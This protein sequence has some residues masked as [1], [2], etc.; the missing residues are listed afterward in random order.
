MGNDFNN[1]LDTMF[2]NAKYSHK[3]CTSCPYSLL[4]AK[5]KRIKSKMI[6]IKKTALNADT[7]DEY[8]QIIVDGFATIYKLL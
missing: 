3:S 2:G 7:K 6:N 8:N 1:I 4:P 5:I